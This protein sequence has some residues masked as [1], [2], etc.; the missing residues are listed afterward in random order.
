MYFRMDKVYIYALVKVPHWH[1][2][3]VS[4]TTMSP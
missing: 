3:Q 4:D 1:A 2:A